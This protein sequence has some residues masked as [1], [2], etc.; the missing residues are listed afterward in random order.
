M[1]LTMSKDGHLRATVRIEH[2]IGREELIAACVLD[3]P[4][5]EELTKDDIET[6]VRD[7]QA[8]GGREVFECWRDGTDHTAR[9]EEWASAQVRRHWPLLFSAQP[10]TAFN[11]KELTPNPR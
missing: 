10:T 8:R 1:K 2:R 4:H 5:G 6:A 7:C 11:G 9:P 3:L